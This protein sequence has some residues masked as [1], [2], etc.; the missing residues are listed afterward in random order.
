MANYPYEVQK[1][2]ITIEYCEA[3]NIVITQPSR[4]KVDMS[5]SQRE[6]WETTYSTYSVRNTSDRVYNWLSLVLTL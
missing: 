6:L 1:K 3:N 4:I 5:V 2:G